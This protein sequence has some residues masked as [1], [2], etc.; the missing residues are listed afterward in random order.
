M[1]DTAPALRPVAAPA[2]GREWRVASLALLSVRFIQGWI[3]WGGGSRRFLYAPQKLD[4]HAHWMAYKFQSALPGAVLGTGHVIAFLLHHFALL[5]AA[6]VAFS[7]AE[8]VCG[9]LLLAGL[10]TRLA[11]A[12]TVLFSV[13]LMLT[14]G[15]QGAT[16]IDEWTMA[17][18]NTAMGVTLMLA[19]AGAYSLD[20][21]LLRR[22]PAL[23][24]R[25]WFR[26]LGGSLPL[27]LAEHGSRMLALILT[28]FTIAFTLSTYSYY[29]GSVVTAFHGGP[30]SPSAHHISMQ[31]GQL[32]ADG[33]VRFHA[34]VDAGTAAAPSHIL[35]AALVQ[36]GSDKVVE[37]WGE[38]ALAALPQTAFR[39]DF[40]YLKLEPGR[41][42]LTAPVGAAATITL[43]PS[44]G[45]LRP[46]GPAE[47]Q[48]TTVGGEIFRLPLAAAPH[49]GS[50]PT[51]GNG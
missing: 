33:S 40:A 17:A 1:T 22:F 13:L 39:N 11:A 30:V 4:P 36:R 44:A 28:A 18:A 50:Q 9:L 7:A 2:L 14:F 41:F 27:P 42:G 5:Y 35:A 19:G 37:H 15:W 38:H 51:K 25:S 34:F 8:L 45:T 26:W 12:G 32:L 46:A 6:L 23:A 3:Y 43:P 49:G 29:R 10:L 31:H 20:N 21:A 47:L 48:L 24:E 16:C